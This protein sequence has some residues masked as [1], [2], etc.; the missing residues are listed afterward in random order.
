MAFVQ[1]PVDTFLNGAE[2]KC[3]VTRFLTEVS[4]CAD[5]IFQNHLGGCSSVKDYQDDLSL[6]LK[7][8]YPQICQVLNPFRKTVSFRGRFHHLAL[9][10]LEDRSNGEWPKVSG[11]CF[12]CK[13]FLPLCF[14]LSSE[15]IRTIGS[16][17]PLN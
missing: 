2:E 10:M 1:I 8:E 7:C 5:R 4:I 12:T 15:T 11:H 16:V 6:Y 13:L 17:L 9:V 3:P 14:D